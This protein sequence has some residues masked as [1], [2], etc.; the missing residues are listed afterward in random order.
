MIIWYFVLNNYD[1]LMIISTSN[2]LFLYSVNI[3]IMQNFFSTNFRKTG[4]FKQTIPD[5][6]TLA[7][8][9]SKVSSVMVTKKFRRF[10]EALYVKFIFLNRT[11]LYRALNNQYHANFLP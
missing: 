1:G 3:Y 6:I 4:R 5:I 11:L 2:N 8:G 9:R 7:K 10:P